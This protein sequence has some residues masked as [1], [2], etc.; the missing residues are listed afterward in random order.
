MNDE[1][2]EL[3]LADINTIKL[4]YKI[5]PDITNDSK[6]YGTYTSFLVMG[7]AEKVQRAKNG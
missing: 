3:T 4:L 5:K 2:E 6:P 7:S 1:R